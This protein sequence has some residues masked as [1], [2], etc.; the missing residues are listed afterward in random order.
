MSVKPGSLKQK[1]KGPDI[2]MSQ[3]KLKMLVWVE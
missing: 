3:F 2:D 1:T